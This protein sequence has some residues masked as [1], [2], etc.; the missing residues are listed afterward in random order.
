MVATRNPARNPA[1]LT[2]LLLGTIALAGCTAEPEAAEAEDPE[3]TTRQTVQDGKVLL[4]VDSVKGDFIYDDLIIMVN[5]EPWHFGGHMDAAE[6]LYEVE[7]KDERTD[8]LKIGDVIR[9]PITGQADIELRHAPTG[10]S[11]QQINVFV[12]DTEAPDAPDLTAPAQGASGI[13]RQAQFSW[14]LVQDE[15][16]VT[17]ELEYWLASNSVSTPATKVTEIQGGSYSIPK[18]EE[19]LPG[20][21][22]HWH[23][24][25]IDAFGNVGDWSEEYEFTTTL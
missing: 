3:L 14:K 13:S 11:L 8:A 22:Y 7:G 4:A 10:D 2:A 23:V 9:L 24:R 5:N 19:L 6:R 25:A 15:S 17:Y 21:T 20:A 18:S 1:I 12:R 16:G